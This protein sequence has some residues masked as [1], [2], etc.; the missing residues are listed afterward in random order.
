MPTSK[1][2]VFI[3]STIFDFRDLRSALKY[4]LQELG[5]EVMLSEFNDFSKPIDEDSYTACLEAIEN[6]N[7]FILL[8]GGRVGGLFDIAKKIS[9]TRMEYRRAYELFNAGRT[10]LVT[11]VRNEIWI[12]RE[13]RRALQEVLTDQ[14]KARYEIVDIDLRAMAHH[15][16]TIVN[17]AAA[18]FDFLKEV[19][20]VEEMKKATHGE[21]PFP[22][23]NWIYQF[24]TFEDIAD[25]LRTE[26]NIS[27]SL[28]KIALI[29]NLKRELLHNLIEITQKR[30]DGE[31]I[32][33]SAFFT[34]AS[35]SRLHGNWN[36]STEM[37]DRYLRWLIMYLLTVGSGQKLSTQFIDQALSTGEF[38]EYDPDTG[39][40]K[41]G[42]LNNALIQLRQNTDRL[43]S[44]S[45]PDFREQVAVF[46]S[47]YQPHI[48]SGGDVSISNRELVPVF[49]ISDCEQ[50]VTELS[51]ALF[52]AL[53]GNHEEL[54][55][56]TLRPTSPL[57]TEAEQIESETPTIKDIADWIN[58]Q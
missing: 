8:I 54:K 21:G 42:L 39:V 2:K 35:R 51:C 34:S 33:R 32:P 11:F 7:Y 19:G 30:K 25:A 4:W 47:K 37:P 22:K 45:G 58:S 36:D 50:N 40:Y 48:Y 10:K 43:R 46:I 31:I 41:S 57:L 13:D 38:L 5:Y 3:S 49:A 55:V 17:D 29:E 28:S 26:F 24:S 6:A 1:P 27:Q 52:K 44:I 18:T 12:V 9:I 20:R 23:G 14:Y 56:I 15:S 16:S 53:E